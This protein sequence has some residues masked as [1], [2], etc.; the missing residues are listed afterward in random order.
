M[1]HSLARAVRIIPAIALAGIALAAVAYVS[2]D[3]GRRL[4]YE[5]MG[6]YNGDT[7]IFWAIGR[8]ILNGLIPYRDLFETKPPGIFLLSSILLW[9]SPDGRLAAI[10]QTAIFVLLPLT[11]VLAAHFAHA[12]LRWHG[13]WLLLSSTAIL[14]IL[15]SLYSADRSGEFQVE[16]FGALFACAYAAV[17][18]WNPRPLGWK[19][20]LLASACLFGAIGLKEPFALT[21]FAIALLLAHHPKDLVRTF[22]IPAG[23][24]A[25]SGVAALALLGYLDPYRTMY[26]PEMLGKHIVS[27]IPLAERG[28][29]LEWLF[30]DLSLTSSFLAVGIA[31]LAAL[32]L[33]GRLHVSVRIRDMAFVLASS[34]AASYLLALAVGI[35]GSYWN[36]H[37]VFAVPGYAALL[38]V[39]VREIRR[40][41]NSAHGRIMAALL[42]AIAMT[43]SFTHTRG[44]FRV[45]A[46][47]AADVKAST[48]EEARMIDTVLDAC[49]I[50]RYLFLGGNG[51]QPYA[52]TLHSPIGP[53]F[54]QYDYWF[55]DSRPAFQRSILDAVDNAFFVVYENV[56]AGNVSGQIRS[57]L[58]AEFSADPW[59][60]AKDAPQSSRYRYLYRIHD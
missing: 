7:T 55:D 27:G 42:F 38:I 54:F 8:G 16:A 34:I 59:P 31:V 28:W 20:I 18:A 58:D 48:Q 2:I 50:D 32:A 39:V 3:L 37:F 33:F 35:G 19:R 57:I 40:H 11:I 10:L 9:L 43:A 1:R 52:F 25:I 45:N 53:M 60:C 46:M 56:Y 30:H 49:G 44:D 4:A 23:I 15:L 36:H 12:R 51:S 24:T 26:L 41:W 17:I 14:S 6:P 29:L 47:I 13:E 21:T 22:C 5:W